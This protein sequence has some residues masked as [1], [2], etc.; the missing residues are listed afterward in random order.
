MTMKLHNKTGRSIN[1]NT[2]L[3]L[4]ELA[5]LFETDKGNCDSKTLSWGND[6]PDH[7]CLHYTDTYSKYM[8]GY[9]DSPVKLF[10]VGIRDKRFPYA[11]CKMWL[12]YFNQIDLYAVDNFWGEYLDKKKDEINTLT[13][14]GVNFIYADQGNFNDWDEILSICP[15]DFD[16]FIED[17]SHWPNHMVV[18]LWKSINL[19][20]SGGYYFMEDLQNP[21]NSR[22]KYKYDNTLLTEELLVAH[23]S[24]E[25]SSLFLN[26]IQNKEVN[27]SYELVD[28]VLDKSKTTYLAVFRRK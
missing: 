8:S 22:G 18:T 25:F 12:S 4:T 13:D 5:N 10:E 26:D 7:F 20:K 24:N 23:T 19:V 6:F 27:E 14:M 2:D 17:G 21:V 9:R 16:F 1:V 11:S 28:M 3:T 15:N